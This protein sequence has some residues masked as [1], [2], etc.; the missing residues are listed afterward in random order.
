[1]SISKTLLAVAVLIFT[2]LSAQ[3]YTDLGIRINSY[4]YNRIQLELRNPIGENYYFRT[5]VSIGTGNNYPYSL[6]FDANDSI[7]SM[8]QYNQFSNAYDLRLGIERKLT[9][10]WLSIN[11]DIVL[12]Y[13]SVTSSNLSYY[14]RVD[15]SGTDWNV[16]YQDS[17]ANLFEDR[18]TAVTSFFNAGLTVGFAFNFSLTPNLILNFTGNY[19]G[20]FRYAIAQR[21]ENDFM[22]E[23]NFSNNTIFDLNV[24]AGIGIRYV[25]VP[26][27]K[28]EPVLD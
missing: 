27:D 3:R 6:P 5:G 17:T 20:V 10:D 28:T 8:R 4:N 15:S 1:M 19:V 23:F 21:E 18:T 9:Y 25:F 14:Y 24:N 12:G 13:A 2:N 16:V 26:I 7:I 11:A 22:N